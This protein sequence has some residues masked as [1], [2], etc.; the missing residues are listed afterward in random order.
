MDPHRTFTCTATDAPA[1]FTTGT[2]SDDMFEDPLPPEH[3]FNRP[4]LEPPYHW[5]GRLLVAAYEVEEHVLQ[6]WPA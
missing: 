2:D 6:F 5:N 4:G 1:D 3:L